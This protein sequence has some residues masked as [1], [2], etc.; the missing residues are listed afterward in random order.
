MTRFRGSIGNK[1]WGGGESGKREGE[2]EGVGE[3]GSN[4]RK[5]RKEGGGG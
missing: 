1:Q 5:M 3:T 4:V 2:R